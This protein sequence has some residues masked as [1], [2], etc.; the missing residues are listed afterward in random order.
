MINPIMTHCALTFDDVAVLPRGYRYMCEG[1]TWHQS[2]VSAMV[3]DLKLELP[4][5]PAS[6]SKFREVTLRV[7]YEL[8]G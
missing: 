8:D 3:E 7:E 4:S 1:Y 2:P 6:T 5:V